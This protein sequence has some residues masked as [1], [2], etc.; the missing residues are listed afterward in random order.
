MSKEKDPFAVWIQRERFELP[1]FYHLF[2]DARK[3]PAALKLLAMFNLRVVEL[4]YL[5]FFDL[6]SK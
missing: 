6:L 1:I 3:A 4:H 2:E 5:P